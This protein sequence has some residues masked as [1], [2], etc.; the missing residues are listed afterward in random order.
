MKMTLNTVDD[1]KAW[2]SV[3]DGVMG[4]RSSGGVKFSENHMVFEGVINTNGGGFSSIRR[5]VDSNA[6]AQA[7]ALKFLVNSDG[8]TYKATI[9]TNAA[10]GWRQVSFQ[11]PLPVTTPGQWE[12]VFVPYDKLIPSIF[13]RPVKGVKFESAKIQ[14]IGII[15]ADGRDGP[16]A[17]AMKEISTC[18]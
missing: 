1:V 10:F 9:R 12:E 6:L 14:S 17:L 13:G 5:Q 15:I 3:N 8:R 7:S 16:F 11:A 4:G 2:R 18:E